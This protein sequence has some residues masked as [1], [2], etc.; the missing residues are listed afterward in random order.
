[1]TARFGLDAVA[2]ALA[3]ASGSP[4]YRVLVGG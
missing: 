1:V 3:L 4:V 2:D